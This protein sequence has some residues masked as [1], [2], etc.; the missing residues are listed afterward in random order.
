MPAS[1]SPSRREWRINRQQPPLLAPI[2]P[3]NSEQA[4]VGGGVG[5]AGPSAGF[6]LWCGAEAAWA[7]G[8]GTPKTR[9]RVERCRRRLSAGGGHKAAWNSEW[10]RAV[11]P[12][13][14][15][16]LLRPARPSVGQSPAHDVLPAT[17]PPTHAAGRGHRAG[18]GISPGGIRKSHQASRLP[19]A[20][21][22]G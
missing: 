10:E 20:T 8:S 4:R 6:R 11:E 12:P 7:A 19:S 16:R 18:L 9:E 17:A 3:R 13:G 14:R 1:R 15:H 21:R 2:P 5:T 22:T